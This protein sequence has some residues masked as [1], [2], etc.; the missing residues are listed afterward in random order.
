[1]MSALDS[2]AS[3]SLRSRSPTVAAASPVLSGF[4]VGVRSHRHHYAFVLS[5]RACGFKSRYAAGPTSGGTGALPPAVLP[6]RGGGRGTSLP[7]LWRA[8]SYRRVRFVPCPTGPVPSPTGQPSI[9]P[10]PTGFVTCPTGSYS[11]PSPTGLPSTRPGPTGII[12]CPTGSYSVPSPTGL[13]SI[14]LG[15]T[16][17]IPCPTGSSVLAQSH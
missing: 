7:P 1:M 14:R 6:G 4:L 5:Y 12:T 15:P 9:R 8:R 3:A 11:A 16:G 13:P 17:I 2:R 10:G